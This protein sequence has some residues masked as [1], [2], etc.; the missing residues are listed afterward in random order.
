MLIPTYDWQTVPPGYALPSGLEIRMNFASHNE[1]RIPPTYT[2]RVRTPGDLDRLPVDV[3]RGTTIRDLR[4]R[5]AAHAKMDI[6]RVQLSIVSDS[7]RERICGD[8]EIAERMDLFDQR[9]NM[10]V[11]YRRHRPATIPLPP[12]ED[13]LGS[14]LPSPPTP[15]AGS[16]SAPFLRLRVRGAG[17]SGDA[18]LF[19]DVDAIN[20][21]F[22][23]SQHSASVSATPPLS[24]R[25]QSVD[26][27]S[28]SPLPPLSPPHVFDTTPR[29]RSGIVQKR[30][31]A[32]N[33]DSHLKFKSIA[34]KCTSPLCDGRS[35]TQWSNS[36]L[37]ILA[38]AVQS[39]AH[40]LPSDTTTIASRQRKFTES[41]YDARCSFSLTVKRLSSFLSVHVGDTT[42]TIASGESV[43][44]PTAL[45]SVLRAF[46]G[47]NDGSLSLCRWCFGALAN[48]STSTTGTADEKRE[49]MAPM[50]APTTTPRPAHEFNMCL[51]F[52]RRQCMQ[53][54]IVDWIPGEKACARL[55]FFYYDSAYA[56]FMCDWETEVWGPHPSPTLFEDV[57]AALGSCHQ[58]RLRLVKENS[59]YD[60]PFLAVGIPLVLMP[61]GKANFKKCSECLRLER[62]MKD[63]PFGSKERLKAKQSYD[64]HQR[65]QTAERAKLN[66]QKLTRVTKTKKR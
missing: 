3:Q 23:S 38:S 26:F 2:M 39:T 8:S 62:L 1:V 52:V 17:T 31:E 4:H 19:D 25:G 66:Q 44:S 65:W 12:T 57:L 55:P 47:H 29:S 30:T 21:I 43:F 6:E 10:K 28:L 58:R 24:E 7:G 51:Q 59:Y 36:D 53:G 45:D 35:C 49:K 18:S 60:V 37:R 11:V 13:H 50:A 33:V 5:V 64:E 20:R 32:S 34:Q 61:E 41:M 56:Y 63:V 9:Y 27:L 22:R 46:H 40:G 16:D 42:S 48:V 14:A 15:V 54:N